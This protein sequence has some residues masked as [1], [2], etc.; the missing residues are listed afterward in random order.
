MGRPGK[1]EIK[2]ITSQMGISHG[3]LVL[4]MVEAHETSK[5]LHLPF[6]IYIMYM[7]SYQIRHMELVWRDT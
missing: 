4:V 7:F 2:P 6:I 3:L 5:S 1:A